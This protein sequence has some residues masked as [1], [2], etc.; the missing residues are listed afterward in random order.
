MET[1][2]PPARATASANAA[3]VVASGRLLSGSSI[4]AASASYGF[5]LLGQVAGQDL[6]EHLAA[7]KPFRPAA[8]GHGE[9]NEGRACADR[10]DERLVDAIG[11]RAELGAHEGLGFE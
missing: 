1:A 2:L 3:S 7:A 11:G 9:A 4:A 5:A 8:A 10:G 6:L